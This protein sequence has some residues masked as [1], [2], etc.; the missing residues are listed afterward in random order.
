VGVAAVNECRK[1]YD[2]VFTTGGIGPTH[3]DIT[4]GSV[5]KAFGVPLI[6]DPTAKATLEKSYPPGSSTT[7]SRPRPLG[8]IGR[9]GGT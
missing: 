7:P 9:H 2:L 6:L 1:R 5:A 4:S 8:G 3:D